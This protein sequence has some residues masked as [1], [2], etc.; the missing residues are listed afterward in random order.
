ML[1]K[2]L[3]HTLLYFDPSDSSK[4]ARIILF[5]DTWKMRLRKMQQ[6][7][8]CLQVARDH[9]DTAEAPEVTSGAVSLTVT[10][11]TR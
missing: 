2:F 11:P 4:E 5:L 6:W 10:P 3:W 1:W 7:A 9:M 8:Q